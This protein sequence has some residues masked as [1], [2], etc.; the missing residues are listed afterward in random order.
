LATYTNGK[1]AAAVQHFGNERVGMVGPH[2][3]ATESR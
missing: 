2:P 3:E 1:I